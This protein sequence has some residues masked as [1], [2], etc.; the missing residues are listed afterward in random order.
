MSETKNCSNCQI[1]QG[2]LFGFV[3]DFSNCP[4]KK[5]LEGLWREKLDDNISVERGNE[6]LLWVST[7]VCSSYKGDN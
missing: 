7:H 5:T 4:D 6:I 3:Y 2:R 1:P